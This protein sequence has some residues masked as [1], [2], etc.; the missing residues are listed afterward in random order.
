MDSFAN[1]SI[2]NAFFAN[3]LLTVSLSDGRIVIYPCQQMTWLMVASPEEQQ[4]FQIESDGY[5]IWWN[6]LDDGIALHHILS[7]IL[8]QPAAVEH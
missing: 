2:K 5:G 1:V 4:D 7:P 6:T 3:N 8:A